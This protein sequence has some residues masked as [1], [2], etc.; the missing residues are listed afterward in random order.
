MKIMVT[1]NS[2][3]GLA[4]VTFSKVVRDATSDE[5]AEIGTELLDKAGRVLKNRARAM[6]A[7]AERTRR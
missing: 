7:K 3:D 2:K 5:A 1:K 6:K 4:T